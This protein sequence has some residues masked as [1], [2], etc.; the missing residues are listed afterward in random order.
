M[1]AQASPPPG[2]LAPET[3]TTVA[4]RLA[5]MEGTDC[6]ADGNLVFSGVYANRISKLT[7]RGV[8]PFLRA[9]SGRAAGNTDDARGRR[10]S[11][12]GAGQR[13]GGGP[14]RMTPVVTAGKSIDRVR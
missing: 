6:D 5:L 8:V 4:A 13:S 11:C 7:G 10:V 14:G 3:V 9:D 12:V 1:P 2:L